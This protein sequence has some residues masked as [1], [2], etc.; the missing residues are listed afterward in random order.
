MYFLFSGEGPTDLGLCANRAS[1]CEGRAYDHGPMTVIADQIVEN[2]CGQ[3]FL[4]GVRYG[5]VSKHA[6]VERAKKLKASKKAVRIPGKRQPIETRYFFRLS[7]KF[8]DYCG[9]GF[10]NVCKTR[11]RKC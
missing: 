8:G 3:S 6:L 11:A 1:A 5:Y 2:K 10:P 9:L 4:K 7:A